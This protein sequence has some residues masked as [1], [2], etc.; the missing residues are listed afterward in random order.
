MTFIK[1]TRRILTFWLAI[2]MA[3][4]CTPLL[5]ETFNT[6]YASEDSI[7]P[8]L[9]GFQ[10]IN[11]AVTRPGVVQIQLNITEEDSGFSDFEL[12]LSWMK[13]NEAQGGSIGTG[14][15]YG[16]AGG[17]MCSNFQLSI[18]Q[19]SKQFGEYSGLYTFDLYIGKNANISDYSI[20]R[21]WIRDKY[22]NTNE[23]ENDILSSIAIDGNKTFSITGDSSGE[24]FIPPVLNSFKIV[25][26]SIDRP[27]TVKIQLDVFEE[28][29]GFS[30]FNMS[31]SWMKNDE[32]QGGSIGTGLEYGGT[33]GDMCSNFQLSVDQSSK[34]FGE[35]SGLY[36]FNLEVGEK[37]NVSS[38]AITE[39]WIRDKAGNETRYTEK[40]LPVLAS[41][42]VS[43]FSLT[44]DPSND[45]FV[46]P[47]LNSYE[48]LNPTV[49]RPGVL[50]LKINITE[51][52]SGLSDIDLSLSWTKNGVRKS[53][54][55]GTGLEY[56]GAVGEMCSNFD[57]WNNS[58]RNNFGGKTGSYIFT[59]LIGEKAD[60]S[61]YSIDR[62]WLRD[63]YG[64]T[65]EAGNQDGNETENDIVNYSSNGSNTF[66]LNDEFS[67]SFTTGTNNP[68]LAQK[69]ASMPDGKAAKIEIVGDKILKKECLDAIKGKDKTIVAY[70]NNVQWIIRGDQLTGETKDL[71]LEVTVTSIK[72]G[73]HFADINN[74]NDYLILSEDSVRLDFYPNG[75]LPGRIQVRFK[76]DTL[77]D[78]GIEGN[79]PALYFFNGE[80]LILEDRDSDLIF[81]GTDKW[82][83]VNIT[84]NSVF[85]VS[86]TSAL[87]MR[88]KTGTK[89][90]ITPSTPAVVPAAP[91]EI[92]DIPAVKISKPKG[93]KKKITVRWKKVSRK[94]LKKIGGI[95]IQVATD[96]GFTNIVKTAMAGKK[97]TS[98]T[99]KGLQ[100][101]KK[102]YVRIRAYAAGNHVSVWKSKS[103]K[104]K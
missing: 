49:N 8:V 90:D 103:I 17:D 102:Y 32:T 104:V 24:D 78:K 57:F 37:A 4:S 20:E 85:A 98:K 26:T 67:Y 25:N 66:V 41:D 39:L 84:H 2:L 87:K 33:V 81:D 27:G 38:Y 21:L 15:E 12:S 99:I 60:L 23:Y 10:V 69:L 92:V 95:Q 36:T 93:A 68:D 13:N 44:G 7:A 5:S 58:N 72:S 54:S 1:T 82:C 80:K 43:S 97:K 62:I 65:F 47:V 9:N 101:K 35:Y 55:I 42:G 71:N 50:K 59:L 14:L 83:Y 73:D 45:D 96:P 48:I 56:G 79:I 86:N 61:T 53:G 51:E 11:T 40:D 19:N 6:A 74:S 29:A 100:S 18:D 46:A 64:N 63:K 31:L 76:S 88:K 3:I 75:S 70:S 91:A 22:G 16:G 77:Y 30:D 28:G 34:Q 89:P 52:G 94:N